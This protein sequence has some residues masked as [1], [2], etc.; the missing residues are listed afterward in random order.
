MDVDGAPVR[1]RG[2][3]VVGHRALEHVFRHI[4]VEHEVHDPYAVPDAAGRQVNGDR[5]TRLGLAERHRWVRAP[6]VDGDG[7][8]TLGRL[9]HGRTVPLYEHG[10]REAG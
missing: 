2:V 4:P 10:Q 1:R 5:M 8:V 3:L 7:D 6:E 9:G